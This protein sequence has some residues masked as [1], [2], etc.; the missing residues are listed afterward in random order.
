MV[1]WNLSEIW[2]A[3]ST[4]PEAPVLRLALSGV[5]GAAEGK[6]SGVSLLCQSS[7]EYARHEG[8]EDAR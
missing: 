8:H 1:A 6:R 4:A 2:S 3:G 7:K 5:E